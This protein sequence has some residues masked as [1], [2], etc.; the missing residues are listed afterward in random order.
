LEKKE[1]TKLVL[2]G[3]GSEAKR[4][5]VRKRAIKRPREKGTISLAPPGEGGGASKE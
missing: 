5:P 2:A 1:P 4:Y 3:D